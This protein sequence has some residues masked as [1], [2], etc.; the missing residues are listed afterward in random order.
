MSDFRAY[1]EDLVGRARDGGWEVLGEKALPYGRQ[2][3]VSRGGA[4]TAVLSCYFGKKGFK[5][6]PGGKAGDDLA[7]LLGG[8][9]PQRA[10]AA[11]GGPDPFDL[12]M[13]RIGADESGK[14]DYFGPL[15]VAA[16][17]LE[18]EHLETL[19]DLGVT[20]SKALGDNRI[21]RIAGRLDDLG[22]G[23]VLRLMPRDYNPR[24][25]EVGNLNHL[26]SDMHGACIAELVDRTGPGVRA[27][28][29]DQYA[30]NVTRLWKHAALPAGCRLETRPKGEADVAV[31]AASILARAEF[32]RSLRELSQEFGHTLPP[33]AGQPVLQAGR[34]LVK[35]FGRERLAEVGKLHFA[36]SAKL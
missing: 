2:Y 23:A 15:V 26:L 14:G 16:W 6:V 25:A 35:L 33:G 34:A 10:A 36:T 28:L 20:D 18:D 17:R 29:V 31:A 27:V 13:P 12:G 1:C 11:S 5:F 7:D 32:V 24:Y 9:A 4:T 21:E 22:C 30:R 3:Q 8:R 19:V